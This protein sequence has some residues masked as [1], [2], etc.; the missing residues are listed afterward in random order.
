MGLSGP[1]EAGPDLG[2]GP[3]VTLNYPMDT[4]I[5]GVLIGSSGVQ[6]TF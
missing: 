2:R 3:G 5:E 4:L 1:Q 6:Q